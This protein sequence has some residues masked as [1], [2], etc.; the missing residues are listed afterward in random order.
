M[1]KFFKVKTKH[2]TYKEIFFNY[3][4]RYPDNGDQLESGFNDTCDHQGDAGN[5][6]EHHWVVMPLLKGQK[7]YLIC[8]NCGEHTHI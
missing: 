3:Y 4:G 5:I 8:A 6:T 7:Q 2:S 1:A